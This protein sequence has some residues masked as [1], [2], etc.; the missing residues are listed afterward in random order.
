MCVAITTASSTPLS[1]ELSLADLSAPLSEQ[2][3]HVST[4]Q[5]DATD[6]LTL[7]KA[8]AEAKRITGGLKG[9]LFNA[10]VVAG[11]GP[12][13][14]ARRRGYG[15]PRHQCCCGLHTIRAS[16]ELFGEH[17]NLLPVALMSPATNRRPQRRKPRSIASGVSISRSTMRVSD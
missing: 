11:T 1:D 3:L 10:A 5:A 6:P 14:H 8:N 12:V 17:P 2:G 16:V 13:Q 4:L 9:V 7:R 15:L